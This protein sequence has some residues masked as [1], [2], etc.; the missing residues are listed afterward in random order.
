M[1]G[2]ECL[3]YCS[4]RKYGPRSMVVRSLRWVTFHLILS[5]SLA[6][7]CPSSVL[8]TE[9]KCQLGTREARTWGPLQRAKLGTWNIKKMRGKVSLR[10][11]ALSRTWNGGWKQERSSF[12]AIRTF[13]IGWI[14]RLGRIPVSSHCARIS[15]SNTSIK[16]ISRLLPNFFPQ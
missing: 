16:L 1:S 4:N 9:W 6:L 12:F 5:L 3:F 2:Q 14:R 15:L 8:P 7:P 13:V 10:S 11:F